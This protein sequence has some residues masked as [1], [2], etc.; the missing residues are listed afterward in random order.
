MMRD[1]EHGLDDLLLVQPRRSGNMGK[2]RGKV[3]VKTDRNL[4]MGR[5]GIT[6]FRRRLD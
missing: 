4:P 6:G 3:T 5:R 2:V 1:L